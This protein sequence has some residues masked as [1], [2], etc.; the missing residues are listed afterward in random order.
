MI[1]IKNNKVSGIP[2]LEMFEK[3]Q[4]TSPLPIVFFYHGWESRKERVLEHG[5]RLAELGFRAV[6]P[7]ALDHGERISENP[8]ES[9][10]MNFWKVVLHNVSELPILAKHYIDNELVSDGQISAAGLSMG[11][12]TVS[13]I[14]TRYDWIHS[15]VILMGSP[16]PTEYSNWLLKN[17]KIDGTA[18]YD[19]LNK[20]E[21]HQSL[22]K[23]DA[24]SLQLQPEKIANRPVYFW[25]GTDDPTVPVHITKNFVEAI[26]NESYSQN[27]IF[28]FTEGVEHK[29]PRE[30]VLRSSD[31]LKAN[32]A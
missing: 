27:L 31:F 22:K 30:I 26:Q 5:Y 2:V 20:E 23:L 19:L 21:I 12:I 13:A 32:R 18:L 15:A 1:E 24:Y 25:H 3:G 11:G 29:V 4:E 10:P 14:L 8:E 9:D 28:E 17:Y 16:D 6:L 7:E